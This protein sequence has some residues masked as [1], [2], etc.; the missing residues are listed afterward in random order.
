M[1]HID[2]SFQSESFIPQE[3]APAAP[4]AASSDRKPDPDARLK[5]LQFSVLQNVPSEA[6]SSQVTARIAYVAEPDYL[7]DVL[8]KAPPVDLEKQAALAAKKK[9]T[10]R[11]L[12]APANGRPIT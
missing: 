2:L 7:E 8:T 12:R 9:Q 10:S 5:H 4:A 11:S 6:R 1:L 3:D